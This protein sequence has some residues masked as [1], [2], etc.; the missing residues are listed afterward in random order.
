[1]LLSFFGNPWV[2]LVVGI[3]CFL[4]ETA[5]IGFYLLP[6]GIAAL[7]ASLV[8]ALIP[9]D[10]PTLQTVLGPATF[11]VAAPILLTALRPLMVRWFYTG[12]RDFNVEALPYKTGYVTER[13]KP[14]ERSGRVR[15]ESEEWPAVSADGSSL[16]VDTSI[17]VI[18]IRGNRLIV[19][20]VR[21]DSPQ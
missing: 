7:A 18:E 4:L 21:K 16:E 5:F 15:V 20:P 6:F 1:M 10:M 19:Q 12:A 8:V 3:I 13:V 17:K 2:W 11:L 14:S 9:A